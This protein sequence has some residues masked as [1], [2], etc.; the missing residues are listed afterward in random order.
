[1]KILI[2]AYSVVHSLAFRSRS[3]VLALVNATEDADSKLSVIAL[4]NELAIDEHGWALIPFG[5]SVH[6]GKDALRSSSEAEKH[7]VI[8]RFTHDDAVALVN[9]YKSA[10][11][12]IKRAVVGLPIFKGHP[13]APRFASMYPDKSPRG[14]IADM[15]VRDNGLALKPVLTPQGGEDVSAGF[16]QFSPYW[17]LKKIGE[18]AGRVV[19]APFKLISIGLV[20][21]GNVP[22]LSLVNADLPDFSHMKPQIIA[23]L[24]AL[25]KPVAADATDDQIIAAANSAEPIAKAAIAAE[26]ELGT[27]KPQLVSLTATKTTLETEKLALANSLETEKARA[28]TA[29]TSLKTE[30]KER[31]SLLVTAA[32]QTGRIPAAERDARTIALTNSAD[33]GAE[34]ARIL[35]MKPTLKVESILHTLS[36]E[37][38]PTAAKDQQILSLTNEYMEKNGCDYTSAFTAIQSD[39]KHAELFKDMKQPQALNARA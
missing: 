19:A 14:S 27:I 22:G 29:E 13:D 6:S 11:S 2:V 33:L 16:S 4:P 21:K 30:R 34:Q 26:A 12:R 28:T 39:P 3:E 10:W 36:A 8:Q 32:I 23:L 17:H 15:E 9:D 25:G 37:R 18:E 5:N 38:T 1:M 20:Q 31:A 7:G 35:A 24:A